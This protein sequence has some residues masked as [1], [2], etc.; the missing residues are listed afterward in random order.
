MDHGKLHGPVLKSEKSERDNAHMKIRLGVKKRKL[1]LRMK[2][3]LSYQEGKKVKSIE[4][5]GS[6]K[7]WEL[8]SNNSILKAPG[9]VGGG[10]GGGGS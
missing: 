10:G 2:L 9:E 5:K 6:V 8:G 4:N 7:I 1:S 3:Q